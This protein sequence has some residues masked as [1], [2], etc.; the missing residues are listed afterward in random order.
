MSACK[1]ARHLGVV[2]VW[3]VEAYFVEAHVT[4][5]MPRGRV[6]ADL[7]AEGRLAG[8]KRGVQV[9]GDDHAVCPLRR[10]V[11]QKRAPR[12]RDA[13]ALERHRV[14]LRRIEGSHEEGRTRG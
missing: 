1:R 6:H 14:E 12:Q 9:R 7:E 13:E 8:E 2:P 3:K 10:R 5:R 11:E 4:E